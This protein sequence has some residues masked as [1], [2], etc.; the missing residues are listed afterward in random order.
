MVKTEIEKAKEK[1]IEQTNK[2]N[3]S[4]GT[5]RNK[6]KGNS[7]NHKVNTMKELDD[8]LKNI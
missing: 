6:G 3:N 4:S 8:L 2:A 1:W 5:M 7:S